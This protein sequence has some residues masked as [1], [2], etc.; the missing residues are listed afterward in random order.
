MSIRRIPEYAWLMM[1]AISSFTDL[2]TLRSQPMAQQMCCLL[3][4]VIATL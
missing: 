4:V 3:K 2:P 1:R